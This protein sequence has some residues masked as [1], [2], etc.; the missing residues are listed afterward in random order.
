MNLLELARNQAFWALDFAK[1]GKVKK[2]LKTLQRIEGGTGVS[3]EEA[4]KYQKEQLEKLLQHAKDTVPI[5]SEQKSLDIND[6]P[7]T[8]KLTYRENYDRSI[9]NLYEKSSL[10]QMSTSGSTGTP[11]VS[12]QNVDKKKHVNAETMFYNGEIGY[13]IGRR[14]IYLRSIV[15]EVQ[16]SE[17]QQFAQNIYLLDCHDLCDEGI[18][19]KLK[20]IVELSHNGGAMLMGYA[21]TLSAFHQYFER[22]G[23]DDAEDANIY[24]V[25][26]GSEMLYDATRKSIEKAFKCKCVSRYANEENG[27]IGQDRDE[28]NV[29]Y[30]NRAHYYIEILKIEEDVPADE[31][32]IGRIVLTDLFNYAMPM[33][34]YDTGDVGAFIKKENSNRK[35]LASFGGRRVDS[36]TDSEGELISPHSITN[37]MWE[38]QGIKQYQFIQKS[39]GVYEIIMN[40]SSDQLDEEAFI[41][42][43]KQ[44]LGSAAKISIK[45]TDD[46][47][48]LAS[49]KRRYIVNEM[50]K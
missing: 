50:N 41:S 27:F 49:G 16:K 30:L 5:F 23:Y 40:L 37:K 32:E 20:R 46:I 1:G 34:R 13:K 11:F 17:R 24:G 14:I 21:S 44:I 12:Y 25:V 48:V 8:N 3:D 26:S 43:F 29:F 35:V 42:D 10:I 36:V 19:E 22:N 2:Y 28:N 33:I 47:P 7:V 4:L 15:T 38:Y 31:G 18:K 45:Y 9:S 39:I 6:W